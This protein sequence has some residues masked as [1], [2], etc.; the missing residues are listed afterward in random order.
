MDTAGMYL[1]VRGACTRR[2]RM[3]PPK[4]AM[5]TAA[6]PTTDPHGPP[7]RPGFCS[8]RKQMAAADSRAIDDE[9][10]ISPRE[11]PVEDLAIGI[12]DGACGDHRLRPCVEVPA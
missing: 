11:R 3:S 8:R 7:T 2:R 5:F 10:H 9:R 12:T 1:S 6:V 4:H